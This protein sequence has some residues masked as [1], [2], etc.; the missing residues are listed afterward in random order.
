MRGVTHALLTRL[1]QPSGSILELGCGA[2]AFTAELAA[3]CP[4]S[5]V[6]GIDLS[7]LTLLETSRLL[8][9]PPRLAIADLQALPFANASFGMVIALD[10]F[11]QKGVKPHV[12]L[13][14]SWR[15]LRSQG[16]LLVR[17]SAHP[18]LKSA[19][20]T[21]FNT[22]RRFSRVEL[23]H[24]LQAAG[25][26][27][28]ATTYANTLLSPVIIFVRL[29]QRW[30][31]LPFNPALYTAPVVNHLLAFILPLEARW[32]QKHNLA[33]GVSLYALATKVDQKS[34]P[35]KEPVDAN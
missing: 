20:D 11:D 22:G 21:A 9:Q 8:S 25:F 2:G 15:V 26:A 27:T 16:Y 24:T 6:V 5:L 23:I 13:H 1:P 3:R 32:L 33:F 4:A 35:S 10:T 18:W 28:V 19:H 12:A 30:K 34:M 7:K 31:I 17:V 29:L 14:E